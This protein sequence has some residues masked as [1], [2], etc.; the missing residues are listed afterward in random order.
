MA[1]NLHIS[2][3]GADLVVQLCQVTTAVEGQW[4]EV[5]LSTGG[6]SAWHAQSMYLN[7]EYMKL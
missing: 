6:F 2:P 1:E 5:A 4:L 3:V 7:R